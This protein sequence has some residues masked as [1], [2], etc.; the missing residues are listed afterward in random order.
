MICIYHSKDLDG[1]SSGA[2]VKKKYPEAKL[3][4][5]DY[6]QPF[7]WEEFKKGDKVIMIDVSLSMPDMFLLGAT[8]GEGNFTWIDH[9]KSAI[10]DFNKY[11]EEIRI[12]SKPYPDITFD[13]FL[14]FVTPV[15]EIGIAACEIGWKYL[16]PDE[17]IPTAIELLGKYDTW[18]NGDKKEWENVIL[19]FQYGMRL[20]CNTADSFPKE[21]LTFN[22][23]NYVVDIL[24]NGQT[25]LA[26]QKQMNEAAC[27]KAFEAKFKDLRAICLNIGGANSTVFDSVWDEEK[28]DVMIPFQ[29]DGEVWKF[30]L[31]TTK[32][33]DL[34]VYAKSFGGG[35]HA[36][37]CGF[38]AINLHSVLTQK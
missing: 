3:I 5:Y 4:G 37:A 12:N 31:Y 34:S 26:Y 38:Q 29:F 30:S 15:L 10:E 21:L 16:F 6:G 19:P 36:K 22:G 25:T 18:R 7:P 27:K 14:S 13:M 28:Y 9:H 24:H 2:I 11:I 20:I 17:K 33:I 1:Y 32:E 23:V 8:V 35:G